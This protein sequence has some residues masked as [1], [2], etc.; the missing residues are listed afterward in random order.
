MN[1]QSTISSLAPD[2][3]EDSFCVKPEHEEIEENKIS[4][5]QEPTKRVQ[6]V[7]NNQLTDVTNGTPK[8]SYP[9]TPSRKKRPLID[10]PL[11]RSARLTKKQPDLFSS[12]DDAQNDGQ[13]SQDMD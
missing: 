2:E 7:E 6:V 10:T 8:K 13:S 1:D 12:G 4:K 5:D 3:V 11:R 9:K